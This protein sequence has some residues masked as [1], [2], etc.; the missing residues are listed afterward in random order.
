[1]AA[2][3]PSL[4]NKT[5]YDLRHST[6]LILHEDAGPFSKRGSCNILQWGSL[7]GIGSDLDIRFPVFSHVVDKRASPQFDTVWELF[8]SDRDCLSVGM[9]NGVPICKTDDGTIWKGTFLFGQTDLDQVCDT[10]GTSE[11]QRRR[12]DV[13]MVLGKSN[14]SAFYRPHVVE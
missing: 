13:S 7:L 9:L 10:L 5:A 14:C 11:L 3:H 2:R 8:Y 4:R 12:R 6:P 1:M